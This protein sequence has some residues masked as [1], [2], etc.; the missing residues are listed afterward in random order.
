ME[1]IL[2]CI[3]DLKGA[4]GGGGGGG[5]RSPSNNPPFRGYKVH[6]YI[7]RKVQSGCTVVIETFVCFINIH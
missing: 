3:S 1:A 7:K 4:A 5:G 2:K 6:C